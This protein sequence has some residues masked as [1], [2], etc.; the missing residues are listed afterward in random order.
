MGKGMDLYL[1]TRCVPILARQRGFGRDFIDGDSLI[2]S[3][4]TV[5]GSG[6]DIRFMPESSEKTRKK[7]L[8]GQILDKTRSCDEIPDQPMF[9]NHI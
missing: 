3:A 5:Y 7:D 8:P 2:I 4:E 6:K 9:K 1:T